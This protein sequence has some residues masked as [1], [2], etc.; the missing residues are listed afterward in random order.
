ARHPLL[1]SRHVWRRCGTACSQSLAAHRKALELDPGL[2]S[3]ARQ[4][5]T[6]SAEF[7]DLE[8]A[9]RDARKLMDRFGPSVE[10]HFALVS[11]YRFPGMPDAPQH[12]CDRALAID[13]HV[14]RLRSCAYPYY[15]QGSS[16]A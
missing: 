9:Y 4:I 12:H 7:G 8:G 1:R 10:T 14:P 15:M 5:L 13:P 3:A 16:R 11:V 6:H 2:L